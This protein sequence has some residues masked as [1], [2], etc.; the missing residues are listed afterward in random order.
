MFQVSVFI[1]VDSNGGQ[2][3]AASKERHAQNSQ[4]QSF[5]AVVKVT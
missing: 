1:E 4:T 5:S 2:S 3:E